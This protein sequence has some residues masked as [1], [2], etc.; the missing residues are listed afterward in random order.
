[1]TNI[2]EVYEELLAPSPELISDISRLEGDIMILGAGGKMGP[3]LARLAIEAIKKAG[4]DKKVIAA[5][6]F[7][8]QGLQDELSALGVETHAVDLLENK[9]LNNLP[10]AQNVL[11]LAGQKFGTTGKEPFTWAMNAY[12][13]GQVAQ[14]FKNSRIVVFSTGNVY[15]LSPVAEGGLTENHAAGPI[16][17]YAQSCLARERIFQ[18]FSEKNNTGVF[19]YRLN[20]AN[21][22]SYGVILELAKSVNQEKPIDLRMGYVNLIW[23]GDANEIALR[24][25]HHCESPAKI[26]NVTGHETISVKWLA[27]QIGLLL[28]KTPQFI[29]EEEPTALLSNASE[30]VRLFGKPRV[31][32][33]QMI[34]LIANWVKEGGK[35]INKPTHFQEREGQF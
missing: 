21:D 8:E 1:M 12:L 17:E 26:V 11:Y 19:I 23:Q 15:P 30:S 6:R 20:Y 5:S 33:T 32:L 34:E 25:L 13:P 2:Q 10:D 3:A 7:S 4:I 16:G 18:Y 27:E 28:G 31:T 9:Q 35:T 29:N 24:S 14:K 22:T